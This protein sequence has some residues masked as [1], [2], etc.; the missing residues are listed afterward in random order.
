[1]L[2]NTSMGL[3]ELRSMDLMDFEMHYHCLINFK[4]IENEIT[5]NQVK[6]SKK[7]GGRVDKKFDPKKG[8]FVEN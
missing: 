2:Q 7:K 3:K 5:K 6:K 4:E 1:M 8:D